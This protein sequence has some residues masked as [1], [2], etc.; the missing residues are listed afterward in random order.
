M[1][2]SAV[3][4]RGS[5]AATSETGAGHSLQRYTSNRRFCTYPH[6]I[7]NERTSYHALPQFLAF[8]LT[9]DM[10]MLV[11]I[12]FLHFHGARFFWAAARAK[13]R[14]HLF[15]FV[16]ELCFQGGNYLGKPLKPSLLAS[17]VTS[18]LFYQD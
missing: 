7:P 2:C 12:L 11:H 1:T 6:D 16:Y 18:H 4:S 9:H 5:L 14:R 13:I 15:P 3:S 8:V 10:A 17:S